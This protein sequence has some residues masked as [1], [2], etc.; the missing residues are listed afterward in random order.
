MLFLAALDRLIDRWSARILVILVLAMIFLGLLGMVLR[1]CQ[2]SFLWLDPLIRHFVFVSAFL[3]G[4]LAAGRGAHI[5][6]DAVSKILAPEGAW[7]RWLKLTVLC[8]SFLVTLWPIWA[9][10]KLVLVEW[11]FGQKVFFGIHSSFLIAIMPIGFS[12]IAYRFLFKFL[13]GV[14]EC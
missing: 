13:Y 6:V 11:D 10:V 12:L 9:G 1:W 5:S 14:K 7:A 8:L 3:G 2:T 4:V